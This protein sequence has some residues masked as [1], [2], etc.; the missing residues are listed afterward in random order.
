MQCSQRG[1][2]G[3]PSGGFNICL[4][5]TSY[6]KGDAERI[7]KAILCITGLC[8]TFCI[9]MTI[10]TWTISPV[11]VQLFTEDPVILSRSVTYIKRFT[12]MIIP[13]AVQYPLVDE[14]TALGKVKLALFC[15]AFRKFV[16]LTGLI[17]LPALLTA[18]AAFFSEPVSYT[19]LDVYK[20]QHRFQYTF[21]LQWNIRH[22]P[23]APALW[24]WPAVLPDGKFRPVPDHLCDS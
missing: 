5:Y 12:F 11:Y 21:G 1:A 19:H 13:L 16:F 9:L 17:L 7:K 2:K 23:A 6:G 3:H 15:S 22:L 4:L 24:G 8:V 14:T 10:V 20:R 18:D